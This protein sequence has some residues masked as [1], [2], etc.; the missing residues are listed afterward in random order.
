VG[1]EQDVSRPD[2]V[3][4]SALIYGIGSS[5]RIYTIYPANFQPS[6]LIHDVTPL[7]RG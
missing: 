6:Q 3:N 4:H 7:L 5:G 1:S 2:L